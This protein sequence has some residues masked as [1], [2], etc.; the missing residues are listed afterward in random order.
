MSFNRLSYDPSTY[1][2]DLSESMKQGKYQMFSGYGQA[3]SGTC[4][5]SSNVGVARGQESIANIVD[6]ESELKN[7]TRPLTKNP[8]EEYPFKQSNVNF[9]S[10]M[11]DC[12]PSSASEYSRYTPFNERRDIQ[13]I[14][15]NN[16][17]LCE[18]PQSFNRIPSNTRSGMNTRLLYRDN[19]IG[20]QGNDNMNFMND[21]AVFQPNEQSS[22]TPIEEEKW[23]CK[24]CKN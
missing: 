19:Y 12:G 8:M 13:I 20:N 18:N 2:R 21:V 7:L 24:A 6:H 15:N 16:E 14:R 10:Q 23:E 5:M 9:Q 11:N 22:R 4:M 3:P 1:Q 17:G